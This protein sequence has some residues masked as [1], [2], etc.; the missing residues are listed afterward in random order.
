M[1]ESRTLNHWGYSLCLWSE[2]REALR[3]QSLE[4]VMDF[5]AAKISQDLAQ[6]TAIAKSR[7]IWNRGSWKLSLREI[8][9]RSSTWA[10]KPLATTVASPPVNMSPKLI[11]PWNIPVILGVSSKL[12]KEKSMVPKVEQFL[13]VTWIDE[14]AGRRAWFMR[15]WSRLSWF[16]EAVEVAV[17]TGTVNVGRSTGVDAALAPWRRRRSSWGLNSWL[18]FVWCIWMWTELKD[19]FQVVCSVCNMNTEPSSFISTIPILNLVRCTVS[20]AVFWANR[21]EQLPLTTD[22]ATVMRCY[23]QAASCET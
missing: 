2:H 4:S 15:A 19:P 18:S 9:V 11:A 10:P 16:V 20:E 1:I 5:S 12:A 14:S 23:D 3:T 21:P 22:I 7:G 8:F 17:G 6:L 13:H